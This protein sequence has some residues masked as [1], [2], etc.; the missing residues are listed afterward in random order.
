[1]LEIPVSLF[2]MV[3]LSIVVGKVR[4][5]IRACLVSQ[6]GIVSLVSIVSLGIL[7]ILVSQPLLSNVI[8]LAARVILV[9]FF[10]NF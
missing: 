9:S 8:R 4:L 6:F 7:V 2:A 10:A 5:S 1:M 3:F